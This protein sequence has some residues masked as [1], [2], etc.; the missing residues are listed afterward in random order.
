MLKNTNQQCFSSP[1]SS[2]LSVAAVA[3]GV[4]WEEQRLIHAGKQ[5]E[6]GRTLAECGVGRDST[7]HLVLRLL[8][9]KGGFGA[10]LRSGAR[11]SHTQNFDA[12][13]DLSGRR[14][15][16]VTADEKL[17][18]EHCPRCSLATSTVDSTLSLC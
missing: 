16:H 12:C 2:G 1:L 3:V 8:G 6:N 10:L 14:L 5:L 17:A 15:R 18:G 7:V 13:R 4:P 11:A 9:G